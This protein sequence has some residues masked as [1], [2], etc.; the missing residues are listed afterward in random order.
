MRSIKPG[1]GPSMMGAVMGAAA[2]I[3]GVI[4]TVAAARMGVGLMAAFGVV[5]ILIAIATTVYQFKNA[6]GKHRYSQFDITEDGEEIDPLEQRFG[7]GRDEKGALA[8]SDNRFCPFCGCALDTGFAYC[9][10][11]GRKLPGA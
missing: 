5:F 4:W 8:A 6:V 1:R 10:R 9:P 11:C 7:R 2:G 3:F